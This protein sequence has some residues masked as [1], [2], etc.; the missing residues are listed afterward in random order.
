MTPATV[1]PVL[2][3]PSPIAGELTALAVGDR[4]HTE[5][6]EA[7]VDDD[8]QIAVR[9]APS[10]ADALPELD[11]VDCFV[12]AY[13]PENG[14]GLLERVTEGTI[15]L[16]V[17]LLVD[18]GA[19]VGDGVRSHGWLDWVDRAA[20]IEDGERLRRR[21]RSL[22]KRR[23]LTGLTQRSLAGIE[24]AGD[25]IAIV[26]PDGTVQFANRGFAMQFGYGRDDL[27]GRPWRTLFTDDSVDRLETAA[28]PTVADGWRW[29]GSCTGR[30]KSGKTVPVRVRLGGPENGGLVFVVEPLDAERGAATNDS[31]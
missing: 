16:P 7:A 11:D 6:V 19:T 23:R 28:I 18:E 8:D 21:I 3:D 27:A 2:E 14:T 10:V 26:A 25:A 20:A 13:P 31:A 1:A 17:V 12:G 5:Q 29:T 22:V 24:L 4:R 9:T 30:R 15:D